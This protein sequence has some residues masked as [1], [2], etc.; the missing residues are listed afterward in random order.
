VTTWCQWQC[1]ND[2]QQ[3]MLVVMR[4]FTCMQFCQP[5]TLSPT[6]PLPSSYPGSLTPTFPNRY[7]PHKVSVMSG[8]AA[9]HK[10]SGSCFP[11]RNTDLTLHS[12]TVRT[13]CCPR[14]SSNLPNSHT[15]ASSRHVLHTHRASREHDHGGTCGS[16]HLRAHAQLQHQRPL[17]NAATLTTTAHHNMQAN[18]TGSR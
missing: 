10:Q 5:T 4:Q 15:Q 8:V 18:S 3:R 6:F 12:S 16:R 7:K 9:N 13:P 2:R 14:N 11:E 1:T 17:H